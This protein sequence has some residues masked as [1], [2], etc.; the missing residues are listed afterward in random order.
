MCKCLGL[1]TNQNKARPRELAKGKVDDDSLLALSVGLEKLTEIKIH[2]TRL[3]CLV[4][5]VFSNG[6][7]ELTDVILIEEE[8]VQIAKGLR[9]LLLEQVWSPLLNFAFFAAARMLC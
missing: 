1:L 5:I 3:H 8:K 7:S 2:Q 6:R 9:T 4:P